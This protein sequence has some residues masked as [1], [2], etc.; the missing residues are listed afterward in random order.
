[1]RITL[2]C[3]FGLALSTS[4]FANDEEPKDDKK[5]KERVGYASYYH[6]KFHGRKT[7]S[8]E[9][10]DKNA[11]TAAHL[12]LPMGTRVKVTRLD[13]GREIVVRINDRGPYSNYMIDL[14]RAA[15]S[16]L[17]LVGIKRKVSVEVIDRKG[18]T[19]GTIDEN[20]NVSNNTML[21][22]YETPAQPLEE[23]TFLEDQQPPVITAEGELQRSGAGAKRAAAAASGQN[24]D[25]APARAARGGKH[26]RGRHAKAGRGRHAKAARGGR[27]AA[28][29][30][31]GGRH[32]AKASHGKKHAAKAARGGKRGRR[33]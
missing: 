21:S 8:G 27:H 11:L 13:N 7:A 23:I 30:A 15:A 2:A 24:I 19:V 3:L 4:A 25:A 9:V 6:D 26:A 12:K 14:S 1:M 33:R 28:K 18:K 29:A 16:E 20:G 10:Y 17:G 5:P 22:T 31:R 32:A